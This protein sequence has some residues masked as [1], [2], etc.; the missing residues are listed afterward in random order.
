MGL[1]SSETQGGLP[2]TRNR[3][4]VAQTGGGVLS[5]SSH[6]DHYIT[7]GARR[8]FGAIWMAKSQMERQETKVA[9]RRMS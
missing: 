4:E 7:D 2:R 9:V 6:V 5:E 8:C 3:T 1:L